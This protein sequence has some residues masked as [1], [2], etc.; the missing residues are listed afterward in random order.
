MKSES[1]DIAGTPH[2]IGCSHGEQ[3]RE[4]IRTA[5]REG[6]SCLADRWKTSER[7]ALSRTRL[8]LQFFAKFDHLIE[9]LKGIAEGAGITLD[10]TI[11]LNVRPEMQGLSGGC[12]S[13]AAGRDAAASG[14]AL[15]GQN[16]DTTPEAL[17]K[18]FVV[19]MK[20]RN[21]PAIIGLTYPGEIGP[22]GMGSNGV[23]VFGNA[24]YPATWP[25]GAPHNLVRRVLL[26][27]T[28]L[29]AGITALKDILKFSPA[30]YTMADREGTVACLEVLGETRRV[31]AAG[32]GIVVHANHV[33]DPELQSREAFKHRRKQSE[34]RQERLRVLL[35]EKLGV[36]TV[37]DCLAALKDHRH[38]PNSICCHGA[39]VNGTFLLTTWSL[40]ADLQE[41]TL[42]VTCGFPCRNDCE[43]YYF[44]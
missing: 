40:V 27:S 38:L 13:F 29:N 3:R 8:Y 19:R 33:L 15:A 20:P 10:E 9:E 34:N 31:P 6:V 37:K 14:S 7:D 35:Q 23:A 30:N 41:M 11:F 12:T 1:I 5:V 26:E 44:S 18:M 42:S 28:G 16:K 2:Q 24:I 43:R 22:V 17:E 32:T 36:L 4:Q 21:R 25:G 39:D